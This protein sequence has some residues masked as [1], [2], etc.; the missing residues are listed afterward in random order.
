MSMHATI[1]EF[2]TRHIYVLQREN[3]SWRKKVTGSTQT[4]VKSAHSISPYANEQNG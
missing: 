1:R 2:S 4:T 3:D